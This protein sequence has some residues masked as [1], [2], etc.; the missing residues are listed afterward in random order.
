M[1]ALT[2]SAG[3][4]AQV[5]GSTPQPCI[6]SISKHL[7]PSHMQVGSAMHIPTVLENWHAVGDGGEVVSMLPHVA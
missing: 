5:I 4:V 6:V 2:Q 1:P 3:A 7:L